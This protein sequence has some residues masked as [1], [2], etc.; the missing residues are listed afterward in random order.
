VTVATTGL[1]GRRRLHPL[2]PLL[3]GAKM[4]AIA[5][6]YLS[7]QGYARL[8]LER[9][10]LLAAGILIGASA[11]STVS[12]LVT[13]YEVVGRELRVYEGL[14]RRRTRAIPL[15]RV[16]GVDLVRPFFARLAGMAELRLEVIGGAKTEAPLAY[17]S[18]GEAVRLREL[19]LGLAAHRDAD[20]SPEQPRQPPAETPV[21]T[22]ANRDVLIANVLTPL[23]LFLPFVLGA[24]V[25]N[26]WYSQTR[27]DPLGD[28]P[29]HWS[30]IGIGSAVTA[31]VGVV[32]PSVRRLLADWNFRISL[33]ADGLRLRHGMLDTRSQ[34]VPP[35]R[36]Q[37][38][39]IMTPV[40][41]RWLGWVRV[42]LDVAGYAGAPTGTDVHGGVLLPVA[43]RNTA[44]RVIA[45]VLDSVAGGGIDVDAIPLR[46]APRRA[47]LFSPLAW[48]R[49]AFGYTKEVVAARDGWLTHRLVVT[50][51]A[52]AQSVRVVQGPLQRLLRLAD[53]HVDTAA[54]KLHAAGRDRDVA[55]A[56]ALAATLAELSRSARAAEAERAAARARHHRSNSAAAANAKPTY[57]Q[58]TTTSIT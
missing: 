24:T 3:R 32:W 38:V 29:A 15:D 30:L 13:G 51:L 19:L 26:I 45:Q 31:L 21:H 36:V 56:Y 4:L 50:R 23:V 54:G 53:V 40:L 55:E 12:W 25:W 47:R 28:P 37:A 14:L 6:A 18:V 20:A 41:W 5:I 43:G 52:R 22:V 7:W 27:S 16:H 9:W 49:R 34:T 8:G 48:R 11:L 17:L 57:N 42:R 39:E 10:L 33:D 1:T 44:R 35:H 2:T 46:P 58:P